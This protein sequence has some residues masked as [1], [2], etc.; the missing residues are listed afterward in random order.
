MPLGWFSQA[1]L[2]HY[3]YIMLVWIQQ[4]LL[5]FYLQA[6]FRTASNGATATVVQTFEAVSLLLLIITTIIAV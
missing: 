6:H 5:V 3:S 4:M 2:H 1:W